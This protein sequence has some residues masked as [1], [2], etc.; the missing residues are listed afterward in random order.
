[1]GDSG[2]ITHGEFGHFMLRGKHVHEIAEAE[3]GTA[4][5]RKTKVA[6]AQQ[7]R[8]DVKE[9]LTARKE[10]TKAEMSMRRDGAR[11]RYNGMWGLRKETEP[12]PWRSP[13]ALLF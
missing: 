5:M 6:S 13:R 10:E 8:E 11:E 3:R 7:V 9:M 1:M 12:T 2:L 4:V